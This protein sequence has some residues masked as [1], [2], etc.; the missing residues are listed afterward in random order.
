MNL[1]YIVLVCIV[2]DSQEG[3]S[4]L[5]ENF[6]KL[7]VV[8]WRFVLNSFSRPENYKKKTEMAL[9]SLMAVQLAYITIFKKYYFLV[10][11]VV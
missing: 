1:R 10:F 2:L 11:S 8:P 3:E 7:V 5:A 6:V 4:H 9:T